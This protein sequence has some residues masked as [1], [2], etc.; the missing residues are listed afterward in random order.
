MNT[1]DGF[2]GSG[3]GLELNRGFSTYYVN[4]RLSPD[5]LVIAMCVIAG[6]PSKFID[7]LAITFSGSY[8]EGFGEVDV[9]N[10]CC[11]FSH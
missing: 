8:F 4:Y 6:L 1:I 7:E 5:V 11:R 2:A 3:I 10:F 9:L